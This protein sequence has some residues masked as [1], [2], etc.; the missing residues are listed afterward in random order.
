MCRLLLHH[1]YT[2]VFVSL[3]QVSPCKEHGWTYSHLGSYRP[4]TIMFMTASS[5]FLVVMHSADSGHSF[6]KLLTWA[7]QL[8]L[9][10]TGASTVHHDHSVAKLQPWT[11]SGHQHETTDGTRA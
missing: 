7:Q 4:G 11:I 9:W 5:T 8:S 6:M 1:V 2:Q 3:A 10:A